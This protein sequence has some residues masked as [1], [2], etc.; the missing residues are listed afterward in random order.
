MMRRNNVDTDEAE[1][2][3]LGSC[4]QDYDASEYVVRR[5]GNRERAFGKAEHKDIYR[6][7]RALVGKG[8]P[9]D[10]YTLTCELRDLKPYGDFK[11]NGIVPTLYA[12]QESTPSSANVGYYLNEML[13]AATQRLVREEAV[14]IVG[15]NETDLDTLLARIGEMAQLGDTYER[16]RSMPLSDVITELLSETEKRYH[17]P[18]R[19]AG[20]STGFPSLD[21]MT[22]GLKR[23]EYWILAARPSMGK[24]SLAMHMALNVVLGADMPVLFASAEMGSEALG[25]RILAAKGSVHLS[26]VISG[27]LHKDEWVRL[28]NGAETVTT[29]LLEITTS[30]TPADILRDARAM[31]R[32]HGKLGLVVV[33]YLQ[34]LQ[35]AHEDSRVMEVA[36]YSSA[37]REMTLQ[38]DCAALVLSQ[39]NRQVEQ[40][41]D[42][43]PHLK[44]LRDSG[45]IEQ[46]ADVVIMLY[47][48]DYYEQHVD[49]SDIS[50]V[51][52][53]IRK[54]RNGALGTVQL[55][56]HR[57]FMQWE[58]AGE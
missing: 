16:V 22:Q 58:D 5:V 23:G 45:A 42:R 51:Q 50:D 2:N 54:Q 6:A 10:I 8:D 49:P 36:R 39:L 26:K 31:R 15:G 37:F 27:R 41:G 28:F 43:K 55:R 44:D 4:M 24:T 3:V 35:G 19:G 14:S 48:D 13:R 38:L 25:Q 11:S 20:F 40:Q 30:K 7:I 32:K 21:R 53:L 17:D 47:R 57:P 34:L 46:D 18:T 12:I 52:L 29:E 1:R 33:D 56:F 9:V